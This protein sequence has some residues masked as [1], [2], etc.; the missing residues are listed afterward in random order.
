[1]SRYWDDADDI[2]Q[3]IR[4]GLVVQSF[5]PDGVDALDYIRAAKGR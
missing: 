3:R 4:R 2:E 1:M 5:G